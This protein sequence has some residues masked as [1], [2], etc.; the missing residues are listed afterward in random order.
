MNIDE[1]LTYRK[2][3]TVQ[4]QIKITAV[5]DG[6]LLVDFNQLDSHRFKSVYSMLIDDGE[7]TSIETM[8]VVRAWMDHDVNNFS[9]PSLTI[10][11]E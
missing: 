9:H 5:S 3:V 10:S 4:R 8:K 7:L 1:M 2:G 6:T 11:E